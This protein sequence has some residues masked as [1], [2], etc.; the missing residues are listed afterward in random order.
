MN[1]KDYQ[2][3]AEVVSKIADETQ[4]E[5]MIVFLSP[6]FSRDNDRYSEDRFRE[7]IDRRIKGESLKGLNV[8]PKYLYQ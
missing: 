1:K 2:L 6:I 5:G 3:F 7:F 4:R 8:N